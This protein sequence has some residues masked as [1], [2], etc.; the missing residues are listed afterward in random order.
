MWISFISKKY[1]FSKRKER[2]ISFIG[3]ISIVGVALGVASLI[4]V[5]SVM[6][7]F[8]LE[9]KDKIIGTYSHVVIA[10]EAGIHGYKEIEADV[11]K[12]DEVE[13]TSPFISHQAIIKKGDSVF[14]V[15][16]KGI[17]SETESSVTQVIEYTSSGENNLGKGMV[18]LGAELMRNENISFGDTVEIVVPNSVIDIDKIKLKVVGKFSSGRYDYDA[19]MAVLSNDQIRD[20]YKMGDV[21][22][23]IGIKL[24]NEMDSEKVKNKLLQMY[25][26]PFAV[27]SWMDLDRNL[28]KALALEKKMMS[29]ILALIII[30][31]CFNISGSLIMM[32]MEKTRDIGVLKAIGANWRGISLV[33]LSQGII[34]GICGAFLGNVCGVFIAER[35]NEIIG[36]IEK[37][38]GLIMFPN[39]VYYFSK[40]PVV[41][42]NSDVLFIT[43]FAIVLSIFSGIYP[44][45]KASRMDPVEAIRYE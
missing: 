24:K 5:L 4:I 16:L 22:S 12:L 20:I 11:K 37:V 26:Y 44:A 17:D 15:L 2:M 13:S 21:V 30:V 34:V 33:F 9:V 7:G 41:I 18:V 27:K 8:D 1:F 42:N 14:G 43:G 45:F 3:F 36:L 6:N 39:D 35:V 25:G 10:N 28:V 40:I 32:V 19:N 23:G 31:A 38:T 29:L